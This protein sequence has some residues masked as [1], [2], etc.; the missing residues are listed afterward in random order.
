MQRWHL[1]A[2]VRACRADGRVVLLDL[3]RS[4]YLGFDGGYPLDL[5]VAGWPSAGDAVAR[6]SLR[7]DAV[8]AQ[9]QAARLVETGP[10]PA[11]ALQRDELEDPTSSLDLGHR[12][13]H[14]R[15]RARHLYRFA[16]CATSSAVRL[17]WLSLDAVA[18]HVAALRGRTPA[19][20]AQQGDRLRESVALFDRLRPLAF[21]SRDRCLYDSLALVTFLAHE[22]LHARWVIGVR[23][24]PFRAHSWV[25]A[26]DT[27]LNDLH[28][29][30]GAFRPILVV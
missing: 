21:T 15:I 30:V 7:A 8:I 6:P 4:R 1:A 18:A 24:N 2:H 5:L 20:A 19:G 13:A 17:R 11:Q 23:T 25:Q 9:L 26:G 28:E 10:Q 22:R 27:V 29:N 16:A 12:P 14:G 3:R